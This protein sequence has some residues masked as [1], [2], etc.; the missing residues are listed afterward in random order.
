MIIKVCILGNETFND[1]SQWE[2]VISK[3]SNEIEW[4][5]INSCAYDKLEKIMD[6]NYDLFLAKPPGVT[7]RFKQ[8]YDE[9]LYILRTELGIKVFPTLK[10]VLI[11]ENKRFISF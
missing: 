4:L 11:Y 5:M 10:E 1:T 3:Y 8:L 7:Q 6:G 2:N 9:R